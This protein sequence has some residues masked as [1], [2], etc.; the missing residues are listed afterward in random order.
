MSTEA[1][2]YNLWLDCEF[3]G[4]DPSND[5]LLE[6]GAVVTKG[7]FEIVDSYQAV[8]S[9]DI[10]TVKARMNQDEWWPSRPSHRQSMLDE[11]AASSRDSAQIDDEL[12][13][14]TGTYFSQRVVPIGSSPSTDRQ[15]IRKELPAFNDRLHYRTIDV[16]SLKELAKQYGVSEYEKTEQHR[17]LPDIYE[18][19]EELRYL[20]GRLGIK[21]VSN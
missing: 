18:S 9:Q 8:I 7:L 1:Q 15:F 12:V 10:L 6:I 20:I 16:S 3:T 13:A 14:F 19:I 5:K 21:A 2:G 11:I 4:L 17:V